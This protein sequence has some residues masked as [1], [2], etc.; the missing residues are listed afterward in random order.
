MKVAAS[1]LAASL[2]A[3]V[4]S[5]ALPLLLLVSLHPGDDSPGLGIAW[6][7][8]AGITAAALFP[9]LLGITG[10]LV[11]RHIERA[12]FKWWRAGFRVLLGLPLTFAPL[13]GLWING[14]VESARPPY[15]ILSENV[16]LVVSLASGYFAL[17]VRRP[18]PLTTTI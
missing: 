6:F 13:Y 14:H 10:E 17:R 12:K 7:L 8:L 9:L 3:F 15:W 16:L 4:L 18:S 5:L 1:Y 11:R 2:I